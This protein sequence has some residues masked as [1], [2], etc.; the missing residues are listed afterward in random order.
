MK[1]KTGD[2]VRIFLRSVGNPQK[3][4]RD[5]K[6]YVVVDITNNHEVCVSNGEEMFIMHHLNIEPWTVFELLN[7][8]K[9]TK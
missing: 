8:T 4:Y 1:Y 9:F 3:V 5:N 6:V 2:I 7:Q